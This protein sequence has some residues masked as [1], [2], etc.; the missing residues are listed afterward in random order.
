MTKKDSKS[1]KLEKIRHS[2]AHIMA[3]AILEMFPQAKLGIGP[4]I[5]NGFYYDFDLPRPLKPEDL[6]KIEKRMRKLIKQNLKFEKITL[7]PQEALK[8]SKITRQDYK[9]ELIQELIKN[10]EPINFYR[11]GKFEDLCKGPHVNSTKE[12]NGE[13]LKLLS[14]AGA[15]W[16]GDEKNKQLQRIY[17][18]AWETKKELDN[19][20]KLQ[21]DIEKRDHRLLNQDLNL[22]LITD[23]VGSGLVIFKPQGAII[24]REIENFWQQEHQ[25]RGYQLIYTPHIGNQSLWQKSGHLEFFKENMFPAME[26]EKVKYLVK[27]MNCPFHIKVFQSE[28]RSYRDLPLR[29]CELGTVYRY[30]KA[31]TLHGLLRVRSITQDDAHIFCRPDQLLEEVIGVLDLAIYMM[32]KL[33]FKDFEIDLSVRDPKNKKKYMGSDKIWQKAEKTLAL[34]LDKK[35]LK[36]HRAEREAVFYGPKIDFKLIDSLGRGWQGPTIQIDF[37]FPEKFDVNFIN[38]KGKKERV[39]MIH[40]TVIGALERFLG[41]LT[42]HFG[43]AFPVWLSPVQIQIIPVGKAH[44]K[45]S[46]KL[47]QIF[48]KEDLRIFVDEANETVGYKIRKAEKQKVP[49]MLVIG[50]KEMK[51]KS[52]NVRIRGQKAVQK[53][54]QKAFVDKIQKEIANKK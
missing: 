36:Y 27:P 45:F 21:E 18:T 3:A 15:Y 51:S 8:K 29:F 37:N 28:M 38:Q 20:L 2:T 16:R 24:R 52:L 14:I 40:R 12:I 22:Y 50:D 33:G 4:V 23:E 1:K 47:G 7:K 49:Y 10:K 48:E 32:K 25:K 11:S 13:A 43:G 31:G 6:P 46:Q 53:M 17:G 44:L 35:K 30:E 5:K 54:T 39:V 42:E 41:N 34:A 19:Y 26:I 9:R